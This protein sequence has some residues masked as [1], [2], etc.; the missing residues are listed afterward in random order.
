MIPKEILDMN[1]GE[2][3][4]KHDN[5]LDEV[6]VKSNKLSEFDRFKIEVKNDGAE[7]KKGENFSSPPKKE[8][9][10]K[11]IKKKAN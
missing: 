1:A 4:D 6:L 3:L 10:K 9:S 8:Y 2:F 7:Q 5:C 11:I